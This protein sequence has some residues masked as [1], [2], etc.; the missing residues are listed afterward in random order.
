MQN[1]W[2]RTFGKT[3]CT[4]HNYTDRDRFFSWQAA[5]LY[6][7]HCLR[8]KFSD[9]RQ[10]RPLRYYWMA[11]WNDKWIS[12]SVL[13]ESNHCNGGFLRMVRDMLDNMLLNMYSLGFF[14]C[15]YNRISFT[16]LC[17]F[18]SFSRFYLEVSRILTYICLYMFMLIICE[19]NFC[20]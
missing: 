9:F 18:F 17:S 15:C 8:K 11:K 4:G 1:I 16:F 3:W 7:M 14:F 19:L 5:T 13:V 12:V 6:S 2:T 20:K 10:V